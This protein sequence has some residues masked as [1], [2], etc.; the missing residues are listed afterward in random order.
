MRALESPGGLLTPAV[1]QYVPSAAWE[2]EFLVSFQVML[3]LLVRPWTILGE[4]LTSMD[5][6]FLLGWKIIMLNFPYFVFYN[7]NSIS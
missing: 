3:M 7:V 1:I 5:P 6:Y 2:L 4:P